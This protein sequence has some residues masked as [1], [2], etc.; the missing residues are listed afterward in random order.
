MSNGSYADIENEVLRARLNVLK[1][2][3]HELIS[4]VERY[5]EPKKGEP[6]L[7]R[8]QLLL[9]IGNLKELLK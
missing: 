7:H 1:G 4:A 6:Y 8:S 5:V 3:V 9:I 2:A